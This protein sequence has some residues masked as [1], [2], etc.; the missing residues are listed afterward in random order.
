MKFPFDCLVIGGPT[1]SGKSALSLAIA[2]EL[3]GEIISADSMQIYRGMDIGT[4]KPTKA[5]QAAI[6]HH[7]IDFL[8]IRE[9]FSVALY[10]DLATE[11]IADVLKRG[12]L[13]IVTGGT[14]LYID[15]LMNNTDFGEYTPTPG[16]RE[17][18]QR[19]AESEGA[20]AMLERLRII[21][22]ETAEE[23][24]PSNLRRILRAIEVYEETKIPMSQLRLQSHLTP[25]PYRF[26][27]LVTVFQDRQKLYDRINRRVDEMVENG[28]IEE[29]AALLERGLAGNPTAAQAIGYKEFISY[30]AGTMTRDD[31][32]ALLKQRSRHYAKRQITWFKRYEQAVFVPMDDGLPSVSTIKELLE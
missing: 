23:L 8:D 6:P 21:D 31:A 22:P 3:H 2:S 20:G 7:L 4:A 32:I 30:F 25:S 13:P 27:M 5:D 26:R 9:S 12:N 1:A 10:R 28:L 24:H 16:L 15:A 19:R 29:V 14:G 18:L 17:S 11:K